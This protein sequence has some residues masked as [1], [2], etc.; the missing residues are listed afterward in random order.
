VNT[1]LE[2]LITLAFQQIAELIIFNLG[3]NFL[4]ISIEVNWISH[5]TF[6]GDRSEIIIL[7]S[8]TNES[9]KYK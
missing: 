4:K 1:K 6:S 2:F 3:I 9:G 8:Q 5:K 7:K